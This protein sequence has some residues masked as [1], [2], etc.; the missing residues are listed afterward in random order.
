MIQNMIYSSLV[1]LGVSKEYADELSLVALMLLIV[2]GSAMVYWALRSYLLKLIHQVTLKTSN[3]WDDALM[4]ARVF[5]RVLRLIPLTFALIC[6]ERTLPYG[7]IFLKRTLFALIILVGARSIEAFLN[8]FSDIYHQKHGANR[9]PIRPLFQALQIVLYL[10]AGIFIISVL[11]DKEPW[12]LFGLMGGLTAVTMLV[13]KDTILGFVASI[14]LSSMDMV[15]VGDWI[16]MP[17][18]NADGDVIDVALHTVRVQNWDKTITTIPT[19]RLINDSFRNWRGMSISG[20]RR[21]K[22]ALLIDMTSVRFLKPDEAKRFARFALLSDYIN[23]KQNELHDYNAALELP[24]DDDVN[25]RRLTNLGTLRSYLY[26]YLEN[27][28][29]IHQHMTLLV[30][31]LQPQAAGVPIEIYCFTTTTNWNEYEAIQGDIF[32]HLLA[33]LPEFGLRAYQQPSGAD[34]QDLKLNSEDNRGA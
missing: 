1:Y 21:I 5:H 34:F 29:Q 9:K 23:K 12:H 17:Q 26:S 6:L 15:R 2:A 13:F 32:D 25:L 24:T 30:R 3:R 20:G 19:H 31:Q 16:E 27:H 33:I 18:F 8:A 14:Q 28:P 22:R 4:N 7:F 10:F 11:L